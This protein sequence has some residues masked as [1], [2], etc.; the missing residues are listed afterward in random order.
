MPGVY[1]LKTCLDCFV[2]HPAPAEGSGDRYQCVVLLADRNS[3]AF[4]WLES[5][6]PLGALS[7]AFIERMKVGCVV[8]NFQRRTPKSPAGHS[9]VP[10]TIVDLDLA[11]AHFGAA[12][13]SPLWAP[14]K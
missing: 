14:F 9:E 5:P 3:S 2:T 6:P 1:R 7:K 8:L 10:G 12:Q 4:E 13:V 11:V